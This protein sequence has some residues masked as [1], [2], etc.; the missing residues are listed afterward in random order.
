[1]CSDA[2]RQVALVDDIQKW[3]GVVGAVMAT[4]VSARLVSH[5]LGAVGEENA[6]VD[7]VAIPLLAARELGQVGFAECLGHVRPLSF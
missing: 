7:P 2:G 6:A 5:E 1:M 4:A 3:V